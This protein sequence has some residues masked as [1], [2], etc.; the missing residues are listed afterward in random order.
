MAAPR[1]VPRR[2]GRRSEVGQPLAH[3]ADEA[4]QRRE[5][6]RWLKGNGIT[7]IRWYVDKESGEVAKFVGNPAHPGSRGRN[8]AKGP[9]TINQI[10][11]PERILHPLRRT[12][13]RGSGEFE[14][15]SWEEALSTAAAWLAAR[16]L[17]VVGVLLLLLFI[18]G[19]FLLRRGC[20]RSFLG[21]DGER[22]QHHGC[23]D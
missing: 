18:R 1:F 5:I 7:D 2:G 12:G 21:S 9:A 3:R 23:G 14:E 10:Y 15:V 20:G 4:G 19:F 8:C 13:P 11:D 22:S 6:A 17:P 16:S